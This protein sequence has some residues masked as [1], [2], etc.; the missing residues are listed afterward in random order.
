MK[1]LKTT[2]LILLLVLSSLLPA[3]QSTPS[4]APSAQAVPPELLQLSYL[5][6]I[7]RYL[8]RWQLDESEIES[9]LGEKKFIFWVRPVETQLDPGD[10]S[11]F[12]EILFPQLNLS[13]NLKK[14]DYTIEELGTDVKSPNFK[15]THLTRDRVPK[16]QPSDSTVVTV[17]MQEMKDY[18]FRTR[19][20]HDYPDATL[21]QHL[22]NAVHEEAA[23]EGILDTNLPKGEQI[24]NVAPLSP[25]ANEV[26]VFWEAG[27]RL[28]YVAS[29]IDLDNPAVW[30][31][32][33][34]SV[35]IFDLDQQVV[36]SHEEAPGSNRFLTRYEVGRA[37]YNCIVLGQLAVVPPYSPSSAAPSSP[38]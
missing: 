17:D 25:V 7:A 29:D 11:K 28:L 24:V 10:R 21:V 4:T 15:I 5:Y 32:Q 3:C 2:S 19:N 37:L 31:E 26:W 18:L 6:E 23:K 33:T 12:A 34:L 14:T 22:R 38:K 35:H 1:I 13:V 20:K 16:R 36:V 27:H 9:I 30:K 8:Y